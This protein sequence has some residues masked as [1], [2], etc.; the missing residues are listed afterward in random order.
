MVSRKGASW[1]ALHREFH[2]RDPYARRDLIRPAG[3]SP[4]SPWGLQGPVLPHAQQQGPPA[5][6]TLTLSFYQLH[7]EA[8][9]DA[10]FLDIIS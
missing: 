9:Q 8:F 5:D 7:S 2:T 1:K 4:S 6:F 3:P 10:P